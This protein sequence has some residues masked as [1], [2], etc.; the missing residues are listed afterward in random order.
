MT[1]TKDRIVCLELGGFRVE[2]SGDHATS[3]VMSA[4]HSRDTDEKP[5]RFLTGPHIKELPREDGVV[6]Q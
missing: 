2:A 4:V 3:D 5:Q 6:D 1:S